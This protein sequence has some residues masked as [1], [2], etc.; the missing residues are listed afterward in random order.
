[1]S[2]DWDLPVRQFS[3][4]ISELEYDQPITMPAIAASI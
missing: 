2:A 4:P 3:N 1:M